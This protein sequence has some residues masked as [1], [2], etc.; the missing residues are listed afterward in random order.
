MTATQLGAV[1]TRIMQV[2]W[3][4]EKATAREI[5]D[6]LN[7]LTPDAPTAHSTVQTLLRGLM[8]KGSVKYETQGRTFVFRAAVAQDKV[9]K[10][11]TRDL[12][13]KTFGGSAS[14]LVSFLLKNEKVSKKELEEIK[15]LVNEK[16]KKR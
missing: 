15:K 4:R 9:R 8:E 2:L 14:D 13:Q 6:E 1:Q 5:T 3:D 16:S 7:R 12:L 10:N 11:A